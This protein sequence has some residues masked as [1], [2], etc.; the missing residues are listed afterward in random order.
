LLALPLL[1][2]LAWIL[3][4]SRGVNETRREEISNLKLRPA[5]AQPVQNCWEYPK[6][7]H[8]KMLPTGFHGECEFDIMANTSYLPDPNLLRCLEKQAGK[9][10]W[11][12]ELI[13]MEAVVE[14]LQNPADCSTPKSLLKNALAGWHVVKWTSHGHGVNGF[15]MAWTVGN[16]WDKG[17]PVIASRAPYRFGSH[18]EK[19]DPVSKGSINRGW[20]CHMSPLSRRCSLSDD[21]TKIAAINVNSKDVPVRFHD[22]CYPHGEYVDE[23]GRCKCKPGFFPSDDGSQC[24]NFLSLVERQ[25]KSEQ[26]EYIQKWQPRFE[27]YH[28]KSIPD[29]KLTSV[30]HWISRLSPGEVYPGENPE[31]PSTWTQ[32][33]FVTWSSVVSPGTSLEY[34]KEQISRRKLKYGFFWWILQ[35]IWLLHKSAPK[36]EEM[37]ARTLR[38]IPANRECVAVHVRRADSC[39][40]DTATHRSCPELR[41]YAKIV[42]SIYEKYYENRNEPLIAYLATDDP[43]A[44]QEANDISNSKVEWRWQ[45]ITRKR[46]VNGEAVDNNEELFSDE[47]MDELYFDLWA[48]SRCR[49]GLV[50]SLASSVA[51]TAYALQTGRFGY[52]LP[53]VSVD[54]PFG[55]P[56]VA[57][58]HVSD[59]VFDGS[60][61]RRE[62]QERDE[63]F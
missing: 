35:H 1:A 63:L 12:K 55:H 59:N 45:S 60:V 47:A 24:E 6:C 13:A 15:T 50:A 8:P 57:G 39:H 41:V 32:E 46:Y 49:H 21:Q 30:E 26:K 14:I 11:N 7:K 4:V 9:T 22:W 38:V 58:H 40:D 34:L 51:W 52:Y 37:E 2:V 3:V 36:R 18:T 33:H 27:Y 17:I 10:L 28:D 54:V 25:K 48:M 23:F 61:R 20:S 56:R 29:W 53:L 31:C 5:P 42:E 16:H 43:S 62:L 44:V 19:C